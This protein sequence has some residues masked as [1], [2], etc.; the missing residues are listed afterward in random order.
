MRIVADF[1]PPL[2]SCTHAT[3]LSS[4]IPRSPDLLF[5]SC[6]WWEGGEYTLV[7]DQVTFCSLPTSACLAMRGC[8]AL[9]N[10]PP[11]P[12]NPSSCIPFLLPLRRTK[13][14]SMSAGNQV[15]FVM[16]DC[17]FPI[18]VLEVFCLLLVQLAAPL[19]HCIRPRVC[20]WSMGSPGRSPSI[21]MPS[22]SRITV[23]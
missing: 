15:C 21:F 10:P 1:S 5:H 7:M 2:L 22:S 11:P 13:P 3:I 17:G 8:S 14:V 16:T 19:T 20:L 9:A 6:L 4:L 12:F 18:Y 23:D